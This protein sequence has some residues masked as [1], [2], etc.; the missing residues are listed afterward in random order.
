MY[1][2][3]MQE[4]S[5]GKNKIPVQCKRLRFFPI[6]GKGGET[7]FG[8]LG[9]VLLQVIV[10]DGKTTL[11]LKLNAS[12]GLAYPKFQVQHADT[13][14][15]PT[16]VV[17]EGKRRREIKD[18]LS[19]MVRVPGVKETYNASEFEKRVK[20]I[21]GA[22]LANTVMTLFANRFAKIASAA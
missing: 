1:Q 11:R 22:E 19:P 13:M 5:Y 17:G 7:Y 21:A 16:L 18:T 14:D 15:Y 4:E 20:G 10:S 2:I 3:I 6:E 8:K 9:F 12:E